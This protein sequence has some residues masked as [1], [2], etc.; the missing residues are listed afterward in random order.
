MANPLVAI[1]N[2]KE[3]GELLGRLLSPGVDFELFEYA[4][5]AMPAIQTKKYD[6]IWMNGELAS[7][8][9]YER[10]DVDGRLAKIMQT[11][12]IDYTQVVLHLIDV[13]RATSSP[14]RSTPII[15][16]NI[17]DIESKLEMFSNLRREL[18]LKRVT[19]LGGIQLAK[20]LIA[21]ANKAL[22]GI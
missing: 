2:E 16:H 10:V 8:P 11:Q 3:S 13:A 18:A 5:T 14:N 20:K 15:V 17:L 21:S 9:S 12:P 19:Y 4:E 7:G 6:L 1:L 22:Y